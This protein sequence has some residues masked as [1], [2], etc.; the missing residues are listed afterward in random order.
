MVEEVISAEKSVVSDYLTIEDPQHRFSD[1]CLTHLKEIFEKSY[2]QMSKEFHDGTMLPVTIK[3]E[4]IGSNPAYTVGQTISIDPSYINQQKDWDVLTHELVHVLQADKDKP[5][6]LELYLTEGMADYGRDKY[7]LYN[8]QSGFALDAPNEDNF[9]SDSYRITG[10]FLK[11]IENNKKS[12]FVKE[13]NKQAREGTYSADFFVNATGK[14]IDALWEEY[15]AGF[16]IKQNSLDLTVPAG[17]KIPSGTDIGSY[18]TITNTANSLTDEEVAKIRQLFTQVYGKICEKYSYGTLYPVT[19]VSDPNEQGV[20]YTDSERNKIV[21]NPQYL[22]EHP[23][24]FDCLT[25][26]LVHVAQKYTGD[27]P[28][29]LCEGIADYGRYEF[30]INNDKAGWELP[31]FSEYFDSALGSYTS[32]AAFL[33]WVNESY[34]RD[35]VSVVN[36]LC[37]K[38]TYKDYAWKQI[39]GKSLYYLTHQYAKENP[40]P[41][42]ITACGQQMPDILLVD[43]N[44]KI[45]QFPQN[46][47]KPILLFFS[48]WDE[49]IKEHVSH[50]V[51]YK[52][53]LGDSIH[54]AVIYFDQDFESIRSYLTDFSDKDLEGIEFYRD[55]QAKSCF[56]AFGTYENGGY[57]LGFPWIGV[58]DQN[59][60]VVFDQKRGCSFFNYDTENDWC[61]RFLV[62]RRCMIKLFPNQNLNIIAE[63]SPLLDVKF[64]MQAV[65]NPKQIFMQCEEGASER[66]G[67]YYSKEEVKYFHVTSSN[68]SI[69]SLEE[70]ENTNAYIVYAHKPG[71]A[72]LTVHVGTKEL[73]KEYRVKVTVVKQ[74]MKAKNKSAEYR[75]VG[76]QSDENGKA[77]LTV[78]YMAPLKLAKNGKVNIPNTIVL[79][80]GKKAKV[81]SVCEDAF[82]FNPNVKTVIIGS[83][84][85]TI[86]TG[87]FFGC[88]NL[89]SVTFGKK[90]T[91]IDNEAFKNCK[92]LKSVIFKNTQT[93]QLEINK[94]SFSGIYKKCKIKVPGKAYSVYVKKL[95]KAKIPK[96][97]KVVKTK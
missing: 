7:G 59:R 18:L 88:K 85:E 27:V 64:D 4:D 46:D 66:I 61:N 14:D 30:G 20:A 68:K 45:V 53:L 35:V 6:S 16:G 42:S 73:Y 22:H 33:K 24:D 44:N 47:G 19:I 81:V 21:V 79:E 56:H 39:T 84:V 67:L 34:S 60:K 11:W 40:A 1:E 25:H 74:E 28:V 12:G 63:D 76:T 87:A 91:K 41:K 71:T 43:Q 38:G 58:I 49:V 89:K 48:R 26:E 5:Y 13:L 97:A 70:E 15:A 72:V 29:W 90:V 82:K 86:E 50:A 65:T 54:V 36:E 77:S 3:S 31:L 94:A 57:G 96:G 78:A 93:K 51:E 10:G 62:V 95:K 83:N 52:K 32:S 80:D 23:D 17:K 75:F 9:Y 92:S 37:K 55:P 8:E 69:V 2:P